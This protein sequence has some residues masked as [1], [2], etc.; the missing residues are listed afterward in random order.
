MTNNK[1]KIKQNYMKL[2]CPI[3]GEEGKWQFTK[4]DGTP[5]ISCDNDK[6]Q[7]ES[8]LLEDYIPTL[9]PTINLE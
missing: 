4:T 8:L 2:I 6:V 5:Y 3:C 9:S 1:Q 7:A